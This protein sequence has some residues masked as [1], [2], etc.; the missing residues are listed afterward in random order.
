[1]PDGSVNHLPLTATKLLDDVD[2]AALLQA[3]PGHELQPVPLTTLLTL[4]V[5]GLRVGS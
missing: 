5:M 2:P 1:M 4:E 3:A